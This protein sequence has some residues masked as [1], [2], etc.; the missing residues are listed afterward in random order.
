MSARTKKEPLFHIS[1]RD[2][3]RARKRI[4]LRFISIFLAFMICSIILVIYK[5][6]SPLSFIGTLFSGTIGDSFNIWVFLGDC[7]ILLGLGLAL[8]PAFKMKFWNIGA[9]GQALMGGMACYIVLYFGCERGNLPGA[10]GLIIGLIAAIVVGAIWGVIPAIFKAIWN[11]NETLFTLMMNYIA[12]Q[13]VLFLKNYI[14]FTIQKGNKTTI[15]IPESGTLASPFGIEQFLPVIII[16]IIAVFITIYVKKTKQGYELSLVGDSENSAKYAGINVKWVIIRTMIISGA[17][18]GL[19]G[20]LM[21][22]GN[23][24]AVDSGMTNNNG[25]TAIIVAWLAKFN[26]LY[27]ILTAGLVAFLQ[28]GMKDVTANAGITSDG[29]TNIFIGIFF[30]F[31]IAFE[32]FII[33]RINLRKNDEGE[34]DNKFFRFLHNKIYIP[35][36]IFNNKVIDAIKNFFIKLGSKLFKKKNKELVDDTNIKEVVNEKVDIDELPIEDDNP[37]ELDTSKDEEVGL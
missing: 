8:I 1:R 35:L 31:I 34:I 9:D 11:T 29:I 33:Y 7:A 3:M 17:I 25:F 15:P 36:S 10:L 28:I 19:V 20:W 37:L 24:Q 27:M 32:F 26:P 13:L 4:L 22:V 14:V 12:I 5:G 21:I 2:Q 30:F 6:Y 23:H 16:A 18:C